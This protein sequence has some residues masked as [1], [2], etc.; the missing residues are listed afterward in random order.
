MMV[1]PKERLSEI[2]GEGVSVTT[3]IAGFLFSGY[4]IE[5]RQEIGVA[6]RNQKGCGHFDSLWKVSHYFNNN[7]LFVLV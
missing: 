5:Y 6:K 4:Q 7:I 3:Y 1:Q 2:Q